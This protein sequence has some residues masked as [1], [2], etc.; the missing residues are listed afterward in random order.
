MH[1]DFSFESG[2]LIYHGEKM[3]KFIKLLNYLMFEKKIDVPLPSHHGLK[4]FLKKYDLYFVILNNN[5]THLDKGNGLHNVRVYLGDDKFYYFL[6][7]QGYTVYKQGIRFDE[8]FKIGFQQIYKDQNIE[9][10]G[11]SNFCALNLELKANFVAHIKL[12]DMKKEFENVEYSTCYYNFCK[13]IS[14]AFKYTS[15]LK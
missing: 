1:L 11:G 4:F 5:W 15:I 7:N 10:Q 9:F 13:E 3:E 8:Q 14:N 12:D 2:E 6:N